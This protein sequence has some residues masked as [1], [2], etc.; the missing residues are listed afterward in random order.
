MKKPINEINLGVLGE[1]NSLTISVYDEFVTAEVY[2]TSDESFS[3]MFKGGVDAERQALTKLL[4]E[5]F[6]ETHEN[7]KLFDSPTQFSTWKSTIAFEMPDLS[8]GG[9]SNTAVFLLDINNL[10]K[11]REST[12]SYIEDKYNSRYLKIVNP[13][14]HKGQ[15]A[16]PPHKHKLTETPTHL[17][18]A[19]NTGN[20]DEKKTL[21]FWG[22]LIVAVI[23]AV[24]IFLSLKTCNTDPTLIYR[25][26]R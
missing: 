17:T 19:N 11:S 18:T 23:F 8:N 6:H 16:N 22:V 13:S 24:I 25:Y 26:D 10:E 5:I 9:Y 20:N 2:V 14:R 4:H 15:E 7:L 3:A 1:E 21:N 12:I